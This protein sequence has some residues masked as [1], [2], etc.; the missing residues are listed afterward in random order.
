MAVY[1]SRESTWALVREAGWTQKQWHLHHMTQ[2]EFQRS[3]TEESVN[4]TVAFWNLDR[5]GMRIENFWIV[6]NLF[7]AART[8][9][10]LTNNG[11]SVT[12]IERDFSSTAT[13]R[14]SKRW[15]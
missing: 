4:T 2:T 11:M 9:S 7:K 8:S 12:I 3:T 1:C 6:P 10:D 5:G 14:E 15:N 13:A